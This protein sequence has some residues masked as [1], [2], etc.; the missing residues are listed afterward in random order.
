M[1]NI[2]K[3]DF[4]LRLLQSWFKEYFNSEIMAQLE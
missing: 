4:T 3:L 1:A 2:L